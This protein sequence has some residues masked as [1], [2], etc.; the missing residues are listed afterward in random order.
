MAIVLGLF[1]SWI[2]ATP[3]RFPGNN[4]TGGASCDCSGV[5]KKTCKVLCE[6]D[7]GLNEVQRCISGTTGNC[8]K[9]SEYDCGFGC[10]PFVEK[11]E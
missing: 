9:D 11:C 10:V 8:K 4:V 7:T 3:Q 2:V 5:K 6:T 1:V